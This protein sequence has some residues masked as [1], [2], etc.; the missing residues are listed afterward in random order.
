MDAIHDKS[1]VAAKPVTATSP[2]YDSSDGLRL[3]PPS[4]PCDS[5]IEYMNEGAANVVYRFS[6]PKPKAGP[7]AL[8]TSNGALEGHDDSLDT[9]WNGT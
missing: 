8:L 7:G 4:V 9:F 1:T 5:I 6:L 2:I 3:L